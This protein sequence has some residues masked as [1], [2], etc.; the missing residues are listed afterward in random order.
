M[1][2]PPEIIE[3]VALNVVPVD[4][5]VTTIAG[6]LVPS[7]RP[8]KEMLYVVPDAGVG[9][10]TTPPLR[11]IVARAFKAFWMAEAL[12]VRAAAVVALL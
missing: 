1:P 9:T 3:V 10:E 11:V 2:K 7:M 12:A 6:Q 8:P 4:T 5:R